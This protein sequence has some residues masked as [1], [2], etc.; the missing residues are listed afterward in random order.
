MLLKWPKGA[1]RVTKGII[2]THLEVG[3][4]STQIIKKRDSGRLII[5]ELDT[6]EQRI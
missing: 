6:K 2:S 4:G 3:V 5:L 1:L